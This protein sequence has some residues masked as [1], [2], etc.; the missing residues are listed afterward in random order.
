MS[1]FK[2]GD[3]V[4][5]LQS[6]GLISKFWGR[7]GVLVPGVM[8]PWRVVSEDHE[9]F[10]AV[11]EREIELIDKPVSKFK[12]GDKVRRVTNQHGTVTQV[13][14]GFE[15]EIELID[16]TG[17]GDVRYGKYAVGKP[18]ANHGVYFYDLEL[19]DIPVSKPLDRDKLTDYLTSRIDVLDG[20]RAT[21]G[22]T[23]VTIKVER[24]ALKSVLL[25]IAMGKF[26]G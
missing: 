14:I 13:P 12:V 1:K 19:V 4:Q 11:T 22:R 21:L 23:E 10:V 6:G 8:Y 26:N 17:E 2:E 18:S 25:G 5:I 9:G 24:D 3:K 16:T 20:V 15:F 7:T